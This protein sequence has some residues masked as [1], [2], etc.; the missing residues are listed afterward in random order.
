MHEIGNVNNKLIFLDVDGVLNSTLSSVAIGE[1]FVKQM[2][3]LSVILLDR[4]ISVAKADIVLSSTWRLDKDYPSEFVKYLRQAGWPQNE[5]V[6]LIDKTPDMYT[7]N[8][9]R[10]R[11]DEIN[12]WLKEN[13]PLA[14]A[15]HDF[16]ILDDT[17]DFYDEQPLIHVDADVG[18][19]HRETYMILRSWNIS[20]ELFHNDIFDVEVK[21]NRKIRDTFYN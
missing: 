13:R 18:F 8:K 5:P 20:S 14:R 15:W 17:T 21:L 12:L 2:N 3:P 4:L 16:I 19:T 7:Q 1:S 6:P 10:I 9:R 11:G